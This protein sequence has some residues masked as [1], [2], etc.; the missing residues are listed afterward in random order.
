MQNLHISE[1]ELRDDTSPD[2]TP[3]INERSMK[4]IIVTLTAELAEFK[5]RY[6]Y[7]MNPHV[8]ILVS[9]GILKS[10]AGSITKSR[11]RISL[12]SARFFILFAKLFACKLYKTC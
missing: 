8:R 5:E 6:I 10:D 1:L 2:I 4:K 7:V 3:Y 12:A 11:V 9:A